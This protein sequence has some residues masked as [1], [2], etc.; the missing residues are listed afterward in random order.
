[1]LHPEVRAI[2]D[3]VVSC[4][5]ALRQIPRHVPSP[6]VAGPSPE[7]PP[8]SQPLPQA[9]PQTSPPGSVQNP[10][11]LPG[12]AS[13]EHEAAVRDFHIHKVAVEDAAKAY[14]RLSLAERQA[15]QR[16]YLPP[17]MELQL[18]PVEESLQAADR[19]PGT[20]P[21][22]LMVALAMAAGVGM[23]TS[24]LDNDPT[25]DT[26]QQVRAKL[27]IPVVGTIPAPNPGALTANPRPSNQ[28]SGPTLIGYGAGLVFVSV[29]ILL[30]TFG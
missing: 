28:L 12:E 8:D 25:L 16:Q 29:L 6:D 18:A 15:W 5:Q 13:R 3:K 21:M 14:Q 10:P 9:L 23:I 19:S 26:L 27:S 4:R 17:S 11:P 1:M 22:A 24:G 2:E 7:T 30:T 20:M